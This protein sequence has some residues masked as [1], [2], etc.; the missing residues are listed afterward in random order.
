MVAPVTLLNRKSLP[1]TEGC[2]S[3]CDS[4]SMFVFVFIP[5]HSGNPMGTNF[6]IFQSFYHLLYS[7]VLY[8]KLCCSFPT[9]HSSVLFSG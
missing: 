8:V 2:L 4:S 1:S 7:I 6:P 5:K 3:S 9:G